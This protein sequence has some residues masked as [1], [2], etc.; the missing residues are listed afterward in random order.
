[1]KIVE[2]FWIPDRLM[3]CAPIRQAL[4][5][6]KGDT[7][8]FKLSFLLRHTGKHEPLQIAGLAAPSQLDRC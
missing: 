1:M 8:F 7:E 2:L 3:G 5:V 6:V 4:G